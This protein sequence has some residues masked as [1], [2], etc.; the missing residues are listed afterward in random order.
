MI[1][2]AFAALLAATPAPP[3]ITIAQKLNSQLPLDLM[4]RDETGKVVRLRQ[5]FDGRKPV[6]LNFVYYRCPMLCPIVLDGTTEALTNLKYDIGKEFDVLTVSIDPR[7]QPKDA[8]VMKEKYVKRYGRLDSASGWHFL[9]A[10]ETAIK[11]LTNAVGFQYAYDPKM[12]QF[13]HGAA[14]FVLTPA[15]A[16]RATSS[17]SNTSRA[18]CAWPF[19][20]QGRERSAAWPISSSSSVSTTTRKSANTAATRCSSPAPAASPRCSLWAASSS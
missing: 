9:T 17:A 16:P 7:D 20:K 12:D 6:V 14:L 5:Y 11:Q 1:A 4:L 8:A 19:S 3:N 18:T 13:A 10:N 15:A 2:L